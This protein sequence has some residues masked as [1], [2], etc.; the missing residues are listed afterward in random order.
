MLRPTVLTLCLV[1]GLCANE[2][3]D[4]A[5]KYEQAGDSAA[6]KDVYSK[7]LKASPGDAELS[8]GYAQT[9]ERY[10]DPGACDAY[11][12]TAAL[13]QS[14]GR[15]QDA[16]VAARR[17]VLLDVIAGDHA[18]A[19]T[20]LAK[21]QELGGKGLAGFNPKLAGATDSRLQTIQIPGP[22]RSFARMAAISPS[23]DADD[24][25]TALARNVV[26]NGY[27]ASHSNDELDETEYLKLVQRY[28]AEARELAKL[29]GTDETIRIANCESTQTNDL[30]RVLG[31]RIRGQCGGDLVLETVNAA[32]AFI[33]TDS[34]FPLAELEQALRT[35]KPFSYEYHPSKATILYSPEYWLSVREKTQ[36]DFIDAFLGDPGLSRFYLGMSKL[37]PET[38]DALKAN[39]PAARLRASASVLDFFGGNFEIRQGKAVL[40]GGARSTPAWAEIVGVSPDKGSEFFEKLMLKDDGWLA[41]LYD[42]LA[43]LSAGGQQAS[44]LEYLTE[45]A[46]MKRYYNAIRGRITT[47][48]PARPVFPL[49][50]RNDAAYD[51]PAHRCRRESAYTGR[52]R[53]VEGVV[54]QDPQSQVRREAQQVRCELERPRRCDRGAVRSL[55]QARGQRAAEDLHGAERYRP[56]PDATAEAGNGP[57]DDPLLEHLWGAVH[58]L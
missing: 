52:H 36:G 1:T 35:G 15:P 46:R 51:A 41:S 38:A 8:N 34:G 2:I 19:A 58:D 53:F 4:R 47:P 56:Q 48:G 31:Y 30:L 16:A 23:T 29:A 18:A 24:V 45:P 44:V 13:Y 39:V 10:R 54:R 22:L 28:L 27:Q 7:A 17:A 11:R 43:R 50:C 3:T 21:Y 12:K 20:D 14:A 5:Q 26:T 6:A 42:S 40:P 37:D 32:R 57:E 55:P 49:E 25:L 9:L 33:T